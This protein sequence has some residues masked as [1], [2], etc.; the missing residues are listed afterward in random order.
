MDIEDLGYDDWFKDQPG[1]HESQDLEPARVISVHKE[2]CVVTN[3]NWQARGEVTGKLMFSAESPLDFPTVGDWVLVQFFG[4]DSPAIIHEILPRKSI[5][6]RKTAGKK[7][8]YQAI[9]SNIDLAFVIQALDSDLSI[10]RLERYMVMIGE[11]NITPVILL[12]KKDLLSES[13]LEEK[14]NELRRSLPDSDVIPFSSSIDEGLDRISELLAHGK[15]YCLLGSS[16]VGKTTL[17][18]KLI[19]EEVFATREIRESDGKGKHTT[20]ARQL[21]MLKN[22][23]MIIDTP[24]MRELGNIGVELGIESV[25]HE[26]ADLE[27]KCKF[28]D[29]SHSGEQGCAVLEA[30]ENGSI[31]EQRFQN[32]Q[33]M[34][35]ESA[36]NDMSYHE[37]RIKDKKLGKLI[38]SIQ[39]Q[40]KKDRR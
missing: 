10:S 9:A 29:C 28:R 1:P 32:Y 17:L 22:G 31:A 35:S 27:S 26:F 20:T 12:S 7:I 6:K 23:A 16:G 19:G 38:K 15:T 3:G 40:R 11:G 36:R 2:S 5:L 37:K 4:E 21:I 13:E 30:I 39:Q 33:K 25:F 24:G 34:R 8:E 14:L 18:N